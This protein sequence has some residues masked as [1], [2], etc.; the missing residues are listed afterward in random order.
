MNC[1]PPAVGKH[2]VFISQASCCWN[3]SSSRW[4][5]TRPFSH[6]RR[7]SLMCSSYV[8]SPRSLAWIILL[9]WRFFTR[10]SLFL[11]FS[12]NTCWVG[13]F[14]RLELDWDKYLVHLIGA[15]AFWSIWLLSSIELCVRSKQLLMLTCYAVLL[16]SL[17]PCQ[18]GLGGDPA[19][20][21]ILAQRDQRINFLVNVF[22]Y[23]P[24]AAFKTFA[25]CWSQRRKSGCNPGSSLGQAGHTQDLP[26]PRNWP[27]LCL[28][29]TK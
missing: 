13:I 19:F 25:C 27:G 17:A 6:S 20:R 2:L 26:L 3:T 7:N 1:L 10:S 14:S 21:A 23:E 4:F 15:E 28:H 5:H 22:A 18:T 11:K 9:L 16:N 29:F 12:T 8:L 24:V